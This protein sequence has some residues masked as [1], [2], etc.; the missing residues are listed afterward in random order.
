MKNLTWEI[1]VDVTRDRVDV[2]SRICI[3]PTKAAPTYS[4]THARTHVAAAFLLSCDIYLYM[5]ACPSLYLRLL[6]GITSVAWQWVC[7]GGRESISVIV[8]TKI[9]TKL[10]KSGCNPHH[11]VPDFHRSP[12]FVSIICWIQTA[13]SGSVKRSPV[14]MNSLHVVPHVTYSWCWEVCNFDFPPAYFFVCFWIFFI[15]S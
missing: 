13:Q 9:T 2:V 12:V 10:S 6:N 4:C 15:Q 14:C 3:S 8:C 11:A 5:R 7:G 1:F